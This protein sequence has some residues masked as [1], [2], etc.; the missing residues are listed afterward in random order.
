MPRDFRVIRVSQLFEIIFLFFSVSL[1]YFIT[2]MLYIEIS[3]MS[4][5]TPKLDKNRPI[6]YE[7]GRKL[8]FWTVFGRNPNDKMLIDLS[9]YHLDGSSFVLRR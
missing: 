4:I 3:C 8:E 5:T 2:L 9:T 7:I 6:M 1:G